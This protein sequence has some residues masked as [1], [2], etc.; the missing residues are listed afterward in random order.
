M[1]RT[2]K[3]LHLALSRSL[4][5]HISNY[6]LDVFIWIFNI[7]PKLAKQ[8]KD[9]CSPHYSK[10]V[11]LLES[12]I[13]ISKLLQPLG[14]SRWGS[15]NLFLLPIYETSLVAQT[16]K[17]LP[18]MWETQVQILG[19]E[20]FLEKEMATHS[21]ILAWKISWMEEPGTVHGVTKSRTRLSYFTFFLSCL[22]PTQWNHHYDLLALHERNL[23]ASPSSQPGPSHHHHSLHTVIRG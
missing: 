20:D 17:R 12:P 3:C 19:R 5:T 22:N 16:V 8:S 23:N 15:R 2:F 4:Q 21:S 11:C 14:C 6:V 13:M 1:P 18:T 10:S 7:C 9:T